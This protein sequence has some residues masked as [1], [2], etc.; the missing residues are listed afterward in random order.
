[1]PIAK[2]TGRRLR[3]DKK[4]RE[5]EGPFPKKIKLIIKTKYKK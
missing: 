4:K 3:R 5:E 2:S 1:M